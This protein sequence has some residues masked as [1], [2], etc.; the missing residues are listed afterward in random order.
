L[1]FLEHDEV[2]DV[3][4]LFAD[5]VEAAPRLLLQLDQPGR[6]RADQQRR[7]LRS[8]LDAISLVPRAGGERTEA[9]LDLDRRRGLRDD[10]P[11]AAAGRAL[12]G[13]HLARA[14]G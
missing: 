12:L 3:C 11:V 8:D 10:D 6:T 1:A 2:I 9:T 4:V 5:E 13:H 7:D 14:V